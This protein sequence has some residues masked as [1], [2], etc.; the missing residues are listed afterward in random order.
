MNA[1]RQW[2][3][4]RMTVDSSFPV[5]I[6]PNARLMI[7]DTL[8]LL[9]HIFNMSLGHCLINALDHHGARVYEPIT[10][11]CQRRYYRIAKET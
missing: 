6:A 11:R 10:S 5:A 3:K 8:K 9:D 2:R 4:T 7:F 1:N